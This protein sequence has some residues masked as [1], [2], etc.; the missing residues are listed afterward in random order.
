M[1][2]KDK[3]SV[4]I[5]DDHTFFREGLSNILKSAGNY[6]ILGEASN[7]IELVE[8][9]K[10]HKPDILIVDIS[11]PILNGIDAVKQIMELNLP[12]KVIALSMHTDDSIILNMLRAGAM[13]FLDKNTSKEE[14]YEAIDS[15]VIF[16]RVYFPKSTN[17]HLMELL[18]TSTYKPYPETPVVFTDREIEVIKMICADF[19]TKEISYQLELSPRTIDTH[20]TRIMERMNVK[21][22]AGLVAYAYSNGIVTINA[23]KN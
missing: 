23:N 6:S 9:T 11:M 1:L 16:D 13:G 15:V 2:T 18:T 4:V 7:G 12:S 8:L 20:R 3:I 14:L 22:V 10:L 17:A 5:A 19:S 21:S